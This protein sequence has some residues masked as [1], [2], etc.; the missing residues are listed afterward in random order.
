MSRLKDFNNRI[1]KGIRNN[2]KKEIKSVINI[3]Q[4]YISFIEGDFCP[5]ILIAAVF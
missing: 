2:I 5:M 3:Y 1:I 4:I